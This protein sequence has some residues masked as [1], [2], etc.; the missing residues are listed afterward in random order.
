MEPMELKVES[1]GEMQTEEND[2]KNMEETEWTDV[3]L[4]DDKDG[5]ICTKH[6]S[7]RE[8][9]TGVSLQ[10]VSTQSK[11]LSKLAKTMPKLVKMLSPPNNISEVKRNTV[12]FDT[13]TGA[14]LHDGPWTKIKNLGSRTC[15]SRT[16]LPTAVLAKSP[17]ILTPL[18]E[19]VCRHNLCAA[20]GIAIKNLIPLD[21]AIPE[22]QNQ[23]TATLADKAAVVPNAENTTV[24]HN[25]MC[26]KNSNGEVCGKIFKTTLLGPNQ[27]TSQY[28]YVCLCGAK[29]SNPKELQ[30]HKPL[31]NIPPPTQG[32]A[33]KKV[34][35]LAPATSENQNTRRSKPPENNHQNITSENQT[36]ETVDK[37]AV[38]PNEENPTL[39]HNNM[40]LELSNDGKICGK[41][42]KTQHL[43]NKHRAIHTRYLCP[44]GVNCSNPRELRAHQLLQKY[45]GKGKEC[46]IVNDEKQKDTKKIIWN[47]APSIPENPPPRPENPPTQGIAIKNVVSLAPATLENPPSTPEKYKGKECKIV[48]DEKQ[49][50]TK[51]ITNI[52]QAEN[53]EAMAVKPDLRAQITPCEDNFEKNMEEIE[54][55]HLDDKEGIT[56]TNRESKTPATPD[57]QTQ[58]NVADDDFFVHAEKFICTELSNGVACGKILKT[59]QMLD[60]HSFVHA[61]RVCP[62]GLKYNTPRELRAHQLLQKYK[63]KG[64]ECEIVNEIE[65][66]KYTNEIIDEVKRKAPFF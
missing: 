4:I 6:K 31:Q 55:P 54:V 13:E 38:V 52:L 29:C 7:D 9:S 34:I 41:S 30:S 18:T 35:P 8:S 2:E 16:T 49:K 33:M 36:L 46:E 28:R 26:L 1:D 63:G 62:C 5:I 37:V 23:D 51:E 42:F 11:D 12:E 45:K 66:Q 39:V 48:N 57:N 53:L 27:R 32:M 14:P 43:L 25:T 60:C 65:K 44:C 50:D 10:S 15:R 64:K 3:A 24:V 17:E 21:P 20:R 19:L 47:T 61:R 59:Q 40:C 22:D 56:G 58:E